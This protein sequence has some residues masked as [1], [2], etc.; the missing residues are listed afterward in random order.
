MIKID[1]TA[2]SLVTPITA[3]NIRTIVSRSLNNLN[4]KGNLIIEIEFVNPEK[5]RQLNE[6]HR[7]INLPTDVLSFPQSSI[8]GQEL[9]ILGTIVIAPKIVE[10][11]KEKIEEVLKHGL[12]HLLGYDHETN[13]AAWS[14]AAKQIS[15]T[16]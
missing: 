13:D 15:C 2:G 14:K 12:L 5:I 4:I 7:K 8:P 9:N 16:L 1:I 3:G 10:Q 6:Q 11:K